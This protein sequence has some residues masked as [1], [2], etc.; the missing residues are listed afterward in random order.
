MTCTDEGRGSPERIY[1]LLSI[2]SA[3]FAVLTRADLV[4]CSDDQETAV[5]S[6]TSRNRKGRMEVEM[7]QRLSKELGVEAHGLQR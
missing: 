2:D 4:W 6:D 7:E 3:G 5:P 1:L